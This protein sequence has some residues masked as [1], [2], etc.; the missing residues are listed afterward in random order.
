MS[1]LRTKLPE[2]PRSYRFAMTPLA[3]AMFQLLIFFMLTS[4]L[5]PYSLLTVQT[6]APPPKAP[7]VS[8]GSGTGTQAPAA[9]LPA[10]PSAQVAIWT[11]ES[12]TIIVGGQEFG[13]DALEGLAAALGSEEAPAEVIILVRDTARVQDVATVLAGLAKANV[14]SVRIA[15]GSV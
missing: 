8:S 1:A 7:S 10:P 5:T 2:R 12:E 6:A 15:E 13:F 14:L 3:D 9:A 11:L 4:S